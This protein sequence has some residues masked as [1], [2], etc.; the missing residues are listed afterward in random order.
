LLSRF[1]SLGSSNGENSSSDVAS[2]QAV[3]ERI[4]EA[5]ASRT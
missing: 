5:T 2:T 4:I 3:V 1:G